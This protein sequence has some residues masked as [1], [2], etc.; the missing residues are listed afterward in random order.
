MNLF[1]LDENEKFKLNFYDDIIVD[2]ESLFAKISSLSLKQNEKKDFEFED[3]K[4]IKHKF[5]VIKVDINS[6]QL[7][8]FSI[9][10]KRFQM[11]KL[12]EKVNLIKEDK[13]YHIYSELQVNYLLEKILKIKECTYYLIEENKVE[14]QINLKD[15]KDNSGKNI[16]IKVNNENKFD[17]IFKRKKNGEKKLRNLT[18]NLDGIFEKQ[19]LDNEIFNG[20]GRKQFQQ[21]LD[22]LYASLNENF[23]YY[24]GQS[25]I[26][27]TV[28]LLDYRYKTNYNILYLNM[29]FLFK[30][31]SFLSEFYI[32]LKNEL[33]YIFRSYDQYNSFILQYGKD[34][35]LSSF[36]NV[37]LNRLRFTIIEK[38]IE[39]LLLN[40]G[41]N[42][43]K[44][45]IIIDQYIKH[46]YGLTD[47]LEKDTQ[48]NEYLKFVCCCSTDEVDVRENM[49]NSIFEKNTKKK[50]FISINNLIKIDLSSLTDKQKR[51]FEMFGN[52]PKYFYK[53]KIT[54]DEDLDSLI[55]IL[56]EEIYNDIKKT[57]KKLN[58]ENR[59]IYGLLKVMYNINK[60]IDKDKL[61]SLFDYI[62]LKFI[63]IT[64]NNT[65]EKYFINFWKE[66]EEHFVLNY[67]FPIIASVF[68]MI[69]KEY[70]KK[71][72]K[73]RLI[74]CTEAEEGYILEHLIYLSLDSGE[75]PFK[76][77]LKI[78]KSY[79]VDQIFCL[80]KIFVDSNEKE[81]VLKT[82]KNDYIDGLFEIGKNYHLYQK[83][84]NAPKFD[85]ALLI[86]DQK[87]N[88]EEGDK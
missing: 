27:K 34:I 1:S 67:S 15:F 39:K 5:N 86:S 8:K 17:H 42:G 35:F 43:E 64:P 66:K 2:L 71:E 16:I 75:E 6:Y 3:V 51:V 20:E 44:I 14:K 29:N 12:Y 52:S 23:K 31:I 11:I 22:K 19:E 7:E 80:S 9:F 46:D 62:F 37:D 84:E 41:N 4:N 55:G 33:I 40:F 30:R 72:Y 45:V 69:L 59:V 24:C 79:K 32:A 63:T 18:L 61:N 85:G 13:I 83:N 81:K 57:I 73:Q 36:E 74:E 53:I 56:K 70:K 76:E 26:G 77:K 82:N 78:L 21:E 65:N 60:K 58:I 87:N 50:K 49:H 54:K 88:I 10:Q 38:L 25:G 28:S 68:K 48:S 47:K